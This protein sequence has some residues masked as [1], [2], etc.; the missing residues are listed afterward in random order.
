MIKKAQKTR[1]NFFAKDIVLS[2]QHATAASC[3]C[4]ST[5]TTMQQPVVKNCMGK[6]SFR[7]NEGAQKKELS[8]IQK[9]RMV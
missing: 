1:P 2:L 3:N 8:I 4:Q 6:H 7:R 9:E 5:T